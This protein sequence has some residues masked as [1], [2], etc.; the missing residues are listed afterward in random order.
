MVVGSSEAGDRDRILSRVLAERTSYR[1]S[2]HI[3][4][5]YCTSVVGLLVLHATMLAQAVGGSGLDETI[6]QRVKTLPSY[7]YA[8]SNRLDWIQAVM[9]SSGWV[10]Q[11][12]MC[13]CVTVYLH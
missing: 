1:Y 5:I 12:C 11:V 13:V 9:G 6:V 8:S 3:S 4:N 2:M 7:T 10:R